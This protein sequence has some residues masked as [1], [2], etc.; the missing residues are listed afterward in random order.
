MSKLAEARNIEGVQHR[1]ALARLRG[2]A[3]SAL[4]A[5]RIRVACCDGTA[6]RALV[7][8]R[9]RVCEVSR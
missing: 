3:M 2:V 8:L 9:S 6:P 4:D 1:A 5:G 7:E